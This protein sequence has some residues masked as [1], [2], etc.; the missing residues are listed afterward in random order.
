VRI[1]VRGDG[2]FCREE[3]MGWCEGEG[4]DYVLGLAKNERLKA[5][6]APQL[7]EAAAAYGRTGKAARVIHGVF[8]SDA[9]ELVAGA[10]SHRQGGT[11][12]EGSQ[13][14][15]CGHLPVGRA[16]GGATVV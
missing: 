9:G 8:L 16:V 3:V 5:A 6:I 13:S 12:G 4:V 1:T 10:A 2:G 11:P 14:P 15:F 7:A